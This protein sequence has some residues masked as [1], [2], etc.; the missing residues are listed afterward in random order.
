MPA[1]VGSCLLPRP[2]KCFITAKPCLPP[3]GCPFLRTALIPETHPLHSHPQLT[4]WHLADPSER[5]KQ[6]KIS[7]QPTGGSFCPFSPQPLYLLQRINASETPRIPSCLRVT[8]VYLNSLLRLIN[9]HN[10]SEKLN[11][12]STKI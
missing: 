8:A 2:Y 7:Y 5:G 6:F 3:N 11:P 4:S 1:S 10:F 12:K 9:R